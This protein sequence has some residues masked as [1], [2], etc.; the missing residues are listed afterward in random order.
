[1][2]P[3]E[4]GR[5]IGTVG[6]PVAVSVWLIKWLTSS[7]NGKLDKLSRCLERN[8]EATENLAQRLDRR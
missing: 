4:I 2:T 3:D 1:M 5:I 6:F 8:T 7:L